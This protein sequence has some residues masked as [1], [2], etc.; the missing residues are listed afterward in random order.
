MQT[1]L[2][3]AL[4]VDATTPEARPGHLL[5][6]DGII[7]DLNA[8]ESGPDC[9]TIDLEGRTVLPGLIDCHVHVVA[10]MMDLAANAQLPAPIAI[11]RSLPI[12]R[13]M[14]ERG[15]T[16][17][18]DTGG[19]PPSLAAA[20]A[21]GL[22]PGPRLFT[23]GKALSKTG[24]HSDARARYDVHDPNR[25]AG[26]FGALGRIADG[27]DDVRLACR[28]MLREGASFIKVMGNGGVASPTDPVNWLG[29]SLAEMNAIVDE[30]LDAKTYVAAHVYT[31]EG[32]TRAVECGV[33][34]LEHCNLVDAA[35]AR[36]AAQ[37]EAV[38]VPTL[39]TYEALAQ[40][41]P[42]LG[43][44]PASV[45]KI[46]SVRQ[47]GLESLAI[48]QEA[49]VTMAFGTDLLGPTHVR[50]NEEFAIRAR[51]L[52]AQEI[53]ASATIVGA[54]LLGVEGRLGILAPGAV[55]D[56]IVVDGDPLA[57]ITVL[58][59]PERNLR[60]VIKEGHIVHRRGF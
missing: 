44:P 47:S 58:A 11:L 21:Q 31:A 35:A 19:A 50:Q 14:L 8:P 54:K 16:T 30:A 59:H 4:L 22:A 17:V 48:L 55:A 5:I 43:L 1:L 36:L 26:N 40:D 51:V 60:L 6:E 27:I 18:R 24:G 45:A 15:F 9:L 33:H 25:W 38:A 41:G 46:E 57:D 53:L 29:Y 32:I 42:S 39:V 37:A 20:I 52:S 56:L 3:N 34:S 2:R 49:G 28:Q 12:L 13:G 23:C 7:R 10:S